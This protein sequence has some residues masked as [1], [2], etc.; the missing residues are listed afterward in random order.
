MTVES[1][2]PVAAVTLRQNDDPAVSFP[3]EVP[4]LA[5]FPVVPGRADDPASSAQGGMHSTFFFPQVG[6]GTVASIRLQTSLIFVNAGAGTDLLLEFFDS[7]GDPLPLDLG[8]LG[9]ESSF[10][11]NLGSGEALSVLTAGTGSLQVG[12]ARVTTSPAVGVQ[13]SLRG[14]TF[15]RVASFMKRASRLRLRCLTSAWWWTRLEIEAPVWPWSCRRM[16]LPVA[17]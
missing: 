7:L 13:R 11:L 9:T 1:D 4:T 16:Q 17:T 3:Q 5:T 12:Y 2:A 6:D 14:R 10:D 15:L 8:D